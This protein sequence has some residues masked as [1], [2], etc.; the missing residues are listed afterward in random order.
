MPLPSQNLRSTLAILICVLQSKFFC[1]SL[2]NF[3]LKFWGFRWI[4]AEWG[5]CSKS[6]GSGKRQ[7][8]VVCAEESGGSKN[9]VPDEACSGIPPRIEETCNDHECPKWTASEWSG[10]CRFFFANQFCSH[11]QSSINYLI[12][13]T[14]FQFANFSSLS[15]TLNG[16]L[17]QTFSNY[18]L[19]QCFA[20]AND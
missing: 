4:A 18:S 20:A 16:K 12:P 8:L 7:R 2:E 14:N 11:I 15:L 10:V 6:C 9:R 3:R 17:Y 19:L 5:P 13:F 1:Q